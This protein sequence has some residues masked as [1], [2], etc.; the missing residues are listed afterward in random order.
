[1]L[2]LA[3]SSFVDLVNS[4]LIF[5]TQLFWAVFSLILPRRSSSLW[6]VPAPSLCLHE[7]TRQVGSQK[8]ASAPVYPAKL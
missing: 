3:I 1:M 5:D 6:A 4:Y 7:S 8:F 2:L